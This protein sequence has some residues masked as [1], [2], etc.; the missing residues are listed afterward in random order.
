[1]ISFGLERG[2]STLA[3]KTALSRSYWLPACLSSHS[4]AEQPARH[5]A[6]L[7]HSGRVFPGGLSSPANVIPSMFKVFFTLARV[8]SL[9][10]TVTSGLSLLC[11]LSVECF[12]Q[13]S[14]GH[15][16]DERPPFI[17][18]GL[19]YVRLC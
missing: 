11:F 19:L 2:S 18:H 1:M 13:L 6:F 7:L 9:L 8:G 4:P 17:K 16:N 5:P 10:S 14:N 12:P 3:S 15:D